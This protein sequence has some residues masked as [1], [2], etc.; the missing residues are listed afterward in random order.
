MDL[1]AVSQLDSQNHRHVTKRSRMWVLPNDPKINSNGHLSGPPSACWVSPWTPGSPKRSTR[2][3]KMQPQGHQTGSVWL[4]KVTHFNSQPVSC[5]CCCQQPRGPVAGAKPSNIYIYIYIYI[6]SM[7][8]V[9]G[10]PCSEH[11]HLPGPTF[12]HCTWPC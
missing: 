4:K 1:E 6:W 5:C 11:W 10:S 7:Y 3:P 8:L 12:I 9:W 2:V